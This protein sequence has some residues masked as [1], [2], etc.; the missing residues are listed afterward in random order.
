MSS[1]FFPT[2]NSQDKDWPSD[3]DWGENWSG[4]GTRGGGHG[5]QFGPRGDDNEGGHRGAPGDRS[6]GHSLDLGSYR[7]SLRYGV[8]DDP[9][10]RASSRGY[11]GQPLGAG[12]RSDR[13]DIR[14]LFPSVTPIGAVETATATLVPSELPPE[15][16]SFSVLSSIAPPK[17]EPKG[18]SGKRGKDKRKSRKPQGASGSQSAGHQTRFLYTLKP[19]DNNKFPNDSPITLALPETEGDNVK[20]RYIIKYVGTISA[21]SILDYLAKGPARTNQLPQDAINMLDNLLRWINKEHY[22]LIKT[23]LFKESE[24][25]SDM[26]IF[27]GFSASV[28]PQWKL[29]INVDLNFKAFFPSGNLADVIYNMKGNDMYDNK[30]WNEISERIKHLVVRADHYVNSG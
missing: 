11:Q 3:S 18:G 1:D 29:R 23:G 30:Y 24:Q 15:K 17:D 10:G 21:Q 7:G 4:W 28:R 22:T 26:V 20:L 12:G 16:F 8:Y 2:V 5:Y 9:F 25:K 27:K 6:Q 19:L 14:Y 13:C